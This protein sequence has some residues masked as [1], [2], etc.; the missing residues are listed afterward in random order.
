MLDVKAAHIGV[1]LV[2]HLLIKLGQ[3]KF[4]FHK[5]PSVIVFLV[6]NGV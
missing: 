6:Q 4:V 5:S 2:L 3:V 1:F